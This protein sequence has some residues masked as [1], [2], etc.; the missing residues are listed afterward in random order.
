MKRVLT[1][2]LLLFGIYI[3]SNQREQIPIP[4]SVIVSCR[5]RIPVGI[6]DF[7]GTW[8]LEK[9]E[10]VAE[11]MEIALGKEVWQVKL[12]Q[13]AMNL[14]YIQRIEQCGLRFGIAIRPVNQWTVYDFFADGGP[15]SGIINLSQNLHPV[16]AMGMFE[17]Q[18]LVIRGVREEGNFIEQ[19]QI[20]GDRLVMTTYAPDNNSPPMKLILRRKS[21]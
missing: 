15:D 9:T 7:S 4:E 11:Y 18:T 2:L 5:K 19:R 16:T 1:V 12:D 21:K 8:T 6:P 14:K 3:I 13:I 17:G 20:I 10:N